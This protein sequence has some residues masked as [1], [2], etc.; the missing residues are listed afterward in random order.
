MGGGNM[1]NMSIWEMKMSTGKSTY[2]KLRLLQV[3]PVLFHFMITSPKIETIIQRDGSLYDLI[4]I[5]EKKYTQFSV[6]QENI[7]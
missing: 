3:M 5:L 2:P 1:S 7:L 4:I 6:S